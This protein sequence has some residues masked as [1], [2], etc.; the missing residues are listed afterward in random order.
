MVQQLRGR[1]PHLRVHVE[2]LGQKILGHA[3]DAI[4]D[5]RARGRLC[6]LEHGGPMAV[7]EVRPGVLAGEHF[8][9]RAAHGPYVRPASVARA[10]DHLGGH[11]IDRPADGLH[12]V[13]D[14]GLVVSLGGPK[15]RQLHSA[16]PRD[17]H[18]G[19][20]EVPVDDLAAVEVLQAKQ[21]LAGEVPREV[22]REG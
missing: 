11:P 18:V 8:D 19:A 3:G 22:L 20:L 16:V 9:H 17:E 1:G 12:A 6:Y 7:P 10:F 4:G 2:T 14:G 13:G 5:G 21:Q 15:V